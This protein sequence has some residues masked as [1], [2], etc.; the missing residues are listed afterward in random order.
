MTLFDVLANQHL[1][2]LLRNGGVVLFRHGDISPQ[3]FRL[4]QTLGIVNSLFHL[5]NLSNVS[6][7]SQVLFLLAFIQ[8]NEN[9]VKPGKKGGWKVDIFVNCLAPVVPS[10]KRIGRSQD[11]ST[12]VQSCSDTC[13]GN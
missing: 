1:V 8:E 7:H 10:E 12:G 13:F 9:E 4:K 11:R 2:K 3:K 5:V 6:G